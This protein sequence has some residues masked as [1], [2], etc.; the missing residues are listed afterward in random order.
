MLKF[1]SAL[2]SV[3]LVPLGPACEDVLW[4]T[5]DLWEV[6]LLFLWTCPLGSATQRGEGG[7]WNGILK[8]TS[9][10]TVPMTRTNDLYP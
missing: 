1:L 9:S 6:F 10:C 8:R 4:P 7:S 3:T 2:S 5:G